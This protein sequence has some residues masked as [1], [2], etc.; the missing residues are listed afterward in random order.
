MKQ[1]SN[2]I[3]TPGF[4][5]PVRYRGS[6][7]PSRKSMHIAQTITSQVRKGRSRWRCWS[8]RGSRKI[9][10]RTGTVGASNRASRGESEGFGQGLTRGMSIYKNIYRLLRVKRGFYVFLRQLP[11][12]YVKASAE[13]QELSQRKFCVKKLICDKKCR[14]KVG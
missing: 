7:L 14:L 11:C 6:F 2:S 1:H 10:P 5:D 8:A 9:R 3:N 13:S 4:H 12:L